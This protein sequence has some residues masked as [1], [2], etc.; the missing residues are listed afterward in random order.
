MAQVESNTTATL[1][2]T[3]QNPRSERAP[4]DWQ[5][6]AKRNQ[7]QTQKEVCRRVQLSKPSLATSVCATAES[8]TAEG[9]AKEAQTSEGWKKNI[10]KKDVN[11]Q[12]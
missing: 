8:G 5:S 3:W 12:S 7:A 4:N 6:P 2:Y 1:S 10:Y 9:G 11:K